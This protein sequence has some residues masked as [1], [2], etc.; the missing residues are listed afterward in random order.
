MGYSI[1]SW[2][3]WDNWLQKL[4][5]QFI[6]IKVWSLTATVILC[7]LGFIN[8]GNLAVIWGVIF[9]LKGAFQ[10]ASVIKNGNDIKENGI[11]DK[12]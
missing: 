2:K 1:T 8:G 10:V 12:V 4:F 9:G 6:S 11:I 7:V 5:V 3:F